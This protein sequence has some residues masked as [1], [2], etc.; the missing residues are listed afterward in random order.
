MQA[1]YK[2]RSGRDGTIFLKPQFRSEGKPLI[3]VHDVR[4]ERGQGIIGAGSSMYNDFIAIE[5]LICFVTWKVELKGAL[6]D[7]D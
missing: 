6:V 1:T 5:E 2:P 3:S 4:G 7:M